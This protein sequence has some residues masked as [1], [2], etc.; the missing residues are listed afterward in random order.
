MNALNRSLVIFA[1]LLVIILATLAIFMA[2]AA[3]QQTIDRLGDLVQYLDEHSDNAGKLIVT[4]GALVLIV[5]ALLVVILEVAPDEESRELRVEQSGATT[6][7]PVAALKLRLEEALV[8]IPEVA[9][10]KAKV[11]SVDRGINAHFDLTVRPDTNV[12]AVTLEAARVASEVL[13]SDLGLPLAGPPSVRVTFLATGGE[14][15]ASGGKDAAQGQRE[16]PA[17]QAAS[18]NLEGAGEER[19]GESTRT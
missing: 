11:Y 3:D 1:A 6:I 16:A 9:T 7:V 15:T 17:I 18:T 5:L 13:Q 19:P 2:W 14:A 12:G 10:A 4:L 8:T